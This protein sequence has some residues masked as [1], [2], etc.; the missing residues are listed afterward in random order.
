MVSHA[1][2]EALILK[3]VR[4]PLNQITTESRVVAA[5]SPVV[6]ILLGCLIVLL[7]VPVRAAHFP[8]DLFGFK[9]SEQP[10][11]GV[12]P[13]WVRV[14]ER[15]VKDVEGDGNCRE[16]HFNRCHLKAWLSFLDSIRTLPPQRQLEEVNRYA[17][18]KDYVLDIDNYGVEDYWAIPREFLS[19]GG[20]CE[21]YA[22]TKFFSLRWL[23]WPEEVLRIIV[24]QDTN[25]R[26]PHAVLGVGEDDDIMILDN[27]I[28]DV[29]SHHAIVH[30]APVYSVNE[31][32]WWLHVPNRP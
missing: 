18:E 3:D 24:L 15:Q 8:P 16:R 30:Y 6:R 20:D 19:R 23:G 11:I 31:S 17:N 12:F 28:S 2:R 1:F 4:F 7:S 25:L 26:I 9:Q 5:N 22:I 27:Q 10:D 14:L 21:D 13:Q 32:H 29:V